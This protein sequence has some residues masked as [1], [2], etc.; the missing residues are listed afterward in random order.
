MG[1]IV[2]LSSLFSIS[3]NTTKKSPFWRSFAVQT[4]DIGRGWLDDFRTYEWEKA[5]PVP[6]LAV[7]EIKQLLALI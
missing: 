4:L 1:N 5:F 6:D 7:Q 3:I 2:I